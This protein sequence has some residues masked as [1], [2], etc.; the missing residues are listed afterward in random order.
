MAVRNQTYDPPQ[1]SKNPAL[2][3]VNYLAKLMDSQFSIPGTNFRFGLDGLIGLIPG[4]GDL[5]TFAVSGYML[6]IMAHNG[7]SGYV[8][9]RMV[10][11]VLLD[12]V[13]GAIPLVGDL[14]DFAFKANLKNMRL[15]QQYYKEGRHRGSAWKVI[16]PVLLVLFLIIVLIIYGVYKLLQNIF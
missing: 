13:I 1:F 5:S 2:K 4:A 16:I 15:M 8:L 10:G 12:A 11:N 6:W 7:A 9:A 3:H 14:F